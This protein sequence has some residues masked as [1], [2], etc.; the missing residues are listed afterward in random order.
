M[1]FAGREAE[2]NERMPMFPTAQ[3]SRA[4]EDTSVI[5][6]VVEKVEG[7][8]DLDK[9]VKA[10]TSAP[11]VSKRMVELEN[12]M[13]TLVRLL[14]LL[15]EETRAKIGANEAIEHARGLLLRSAVMD[16]SL[17][18]PEETK[19]SESGGH[20]TTLFPPRGR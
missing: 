17:E 4:D 9:V 5:E 6:Q 14:L 16:H 19:P 13:W 1:S 10:Q 11:Q 7:E 12:S 3:P 20:F 18:V 8:V 15:P 2:M